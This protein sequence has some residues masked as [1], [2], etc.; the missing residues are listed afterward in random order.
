MSSSTYKIISTKTASTPPNAAM[1]LYS[2]DNGD[3][4]ATQAFIDRMTAAF[5]SVPGIIDFY[6]VD[7]TS[8]RNETCIVF[9]TDIIQIGGDPFTYLGQEIPTGYNLFFYLTENLFTIDPLHGG[10]MDVFQNS[11]LYNSTNYINLNV[12]VV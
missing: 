3:S 1:Y 7:P 6:L 11:E 4:V 12:E 10:Y 2:L 5:K 9:D 8:D